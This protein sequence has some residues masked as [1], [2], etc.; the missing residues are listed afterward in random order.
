[1]FSAATVFRSQVKKPIMRTSRFSLLAG[2]GPTATVRIEVDGRDCEVPAGISLASALV[3]LGMEY[4]RESTVSR[5]KRAPY[6]M[7]GACFECLVE[8]DGRPSTQSCLIEVRDGMQVSRQRGAA[9][10]GSHVRQVEA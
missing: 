3:L 7:M 8:V 9:D 4:T 6:C 2:I 5:Q 1:M 10:I